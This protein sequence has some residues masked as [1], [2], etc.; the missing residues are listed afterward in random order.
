[1]CVCVCVIF[2]IALSEGRG[3]GKENFWSSISFSPSK[4]K[5]NKLTASPP[6]T[7]SKEDNETQE[8]PK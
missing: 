6:L 4:E 8:K 3:N 7:F 2:L 1:M 5:E